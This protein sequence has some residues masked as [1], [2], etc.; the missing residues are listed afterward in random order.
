MNIAIIGFAGLLSVVCS[1]TPDTDPLS[2]VDRQEEC[3]LSQREIAEALNRKDNDEALLRR[4]RVVSGDQRRT[5]VLA[6]RL[7]PASPAIT[8]KMRQLIDDPDEEVAF[9]ALDYCSRLCDEK[10]L[11]RLSAQPYKVMAPCLEWAQTVK[12]FGKCRYSDGIP[13]LLDSLEHACLN[14]VG[15]AQ[16]SLHEIV[17]ES[18]ADFKSPEDERKYYE[19][20]LR[21]LKRQGR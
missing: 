5:V 6:M 17:P 9:Y 14:V 3:Q 10:A 2:C 4:L 11:A 7:R 13:F 19:G 16:E 1:K 20:K 18:P 8:K 15:A 21:G 12:S